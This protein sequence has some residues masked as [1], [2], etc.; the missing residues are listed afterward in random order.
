MENDFDAEVHALDKKDKKHHYFSKAWYFEI[1]FVS[2]L[3]CFAFAV[4]SQI[5]LLNAS[6]GWALFLVLLLI[7]ISVAFDVVGVAVTAS[8]VKPFL[9]MKQE[10]KTKGLKTAMWFVKHADK[11]SSICTDVVG[12][13]CSIVSG[14]SGMAIALIIVHQFN[15]FSSAILSILVSSII[16]ALTVLG[17]ALGKTFAINNPTKILVFCGRFLEFF[18]HKSKKKFSKNPKTPVK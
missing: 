16:A 11:V 3:L 6:L 13:I 17:K 14:A 2:L 5:M 1:F 10:G 15:S 4:F 18:V 7:F 9:K 12:D 8:N